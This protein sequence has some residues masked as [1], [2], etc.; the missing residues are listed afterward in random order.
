MEHISLRI[1][2]KQNGFTY[3]C[4]M[5]AGNSRVFYR[6]KSR[7]SYRMVFYRVR[8]RKCL[9]NDRTSLLLILVSFRGVALC[10]YFQRFYLSHA[11]W[12]KKEQKPSNLH[13]LA[14]LS[15][16]TLLEKTHCN[17]NVLC[18]SCHIQFQSWLLMSHA[19]LAMAAKPN[20]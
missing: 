15:R 18:Y 9:E 7:I 10:P 12:R 2:Q 5:Y 6:I 16:E 4:P 3:S 17:P 8:I 1:Q 13:P 11:K 19:I 14:F 20:A